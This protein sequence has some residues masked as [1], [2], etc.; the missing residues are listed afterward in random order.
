MTTAVARTTTIGSAVKATRRARRVPVLS[1]QRPDLLPRSRAGVTLDL[2]SATL[3]HHRTRKPAAE[4]ALQVS[5]RILLRLLLAIGAA[6]LLLALRVVARGP[7]WILAATMDQPSVARR[8]RTLLALS[9]PTNGATL[10]V[11]AATALRHVRMRMNPNQRVRSNH[12]KIAEDLAS[13]SSTPTDRV[14]RT[15][16]VMTVRRRT[17]V[18]MVRLALSQDH[19]RD[20]SVIRTASTIATTGLHSGTPRWAIVNL[21]QPESLSSKDAAEADR[22]VRLLCR[23]LGAPAHLRP[24]IM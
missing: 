19:H 14:A 11:S 5:D 16:S 24:R 21:R 2:V 15:I 7:R 12:V 1:T 18:V 6:V 8:E 10:P 9:L 17:L 13:E 3:T 23:S 20:S 4:L 22:A